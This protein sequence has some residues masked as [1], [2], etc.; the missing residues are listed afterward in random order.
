ED[1]G[2][3]GAAVGGA[4]LVD[5]PVVVGDD[6]VGEVGLRGEVAHAG[7]LLLV[8]GTDLHVSS[9]VR[10]LV[11]SRISTYREVADAARRPAP[12]QAPSSPSCAAPSPSADGPWARRSSNW[13]SSRIRRPSSRAFVS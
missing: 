12:A 11:A 8:C 5:V 10:R 13:S 4:E 7:E 6:V 1:V 9:P 3:V 2:L